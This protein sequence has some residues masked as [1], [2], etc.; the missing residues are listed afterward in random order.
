[1]CILIDVNIKKQSL[2]AE[3]KGG[4]MDEKMKEVLK[5][6]YENLTDEQKKKAD[7]CK[8]NDD[9]MNLVDEWGIELPDELANKIAGGL[10]RLLFSE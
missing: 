2:R 5:G 9:I 1:M 8:T 7:A 3:R 6:I 10:P 4:K